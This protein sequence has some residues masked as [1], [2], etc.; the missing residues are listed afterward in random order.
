MPPTDPLCECTHLLSL[1]IHSGACAEPGCD[2]EEFD[3]V[4]TG[5]QMVTRGDPDAE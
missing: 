1:H 2:C 5:A 4:G 3:E